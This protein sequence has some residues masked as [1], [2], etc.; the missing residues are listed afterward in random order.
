MFLLFFLKTVAKK[1]TVTK[2]SVKGAAY[3]KFQHS[4][5]TCGVKKACSHSEPDLSNQSGHNDDVNLD[6]KQPHPALTLTKFNPQIFILSQTL[7]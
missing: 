5:F 4:L 6:Y 3:H 2:K 1:G 7:I